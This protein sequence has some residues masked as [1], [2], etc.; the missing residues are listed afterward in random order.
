MSEWSNQIGISEIRNAN[1]DKLAECLNLT[2]NQIRNYSI[3]AL[4]DTATVLT[5]YNLY[6]TNEIGRLSGRIVWYSNKLNGTNRRGLTPEQV[7]EYQGILDESKTHH[8]VIRNL[9]FALQ[10]KINL[11]KKIYDGR[12]KGWHSKI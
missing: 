3:E 10:E 1:R 5:Q 8:A 11:L 7:Q 6:I 9:P 2:P 12:I 4:E